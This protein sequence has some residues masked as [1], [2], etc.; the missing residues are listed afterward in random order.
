MTKVVS[1]QAV[2]ECQLLRH[3]CQTAQILQD[4]VPF[5]SDSVSR[6]AAKFPTSHVTYRPLVLLAVVESNCTL[7]LAVHLGKTRPFLV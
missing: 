7:Q 3:V 2:G 1:T 5:A 4:S 6:K